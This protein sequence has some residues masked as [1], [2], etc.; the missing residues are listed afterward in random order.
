MKKSFIFRISFVTP[1]FS[2]LLYLVSVPLRV[3]LLVEPQKVFSIFWNR[4]QEVAAGVLPP[5]VRPEAQQ[6][7][8]SERVWVA[9]EAWLKEQRQILSGGLLRPEVK[10]ECL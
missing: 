10:P 2:F 6:P 3:E 9:P 7:A 1:L 4:N 5:G 8:V